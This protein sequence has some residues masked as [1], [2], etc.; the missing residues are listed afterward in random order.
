MAV[1]HKVLDSPAWLAMSHGARL[2]YISLRRRKPRQRNIVF[3]SY[4][5]AQA[6]LRSGPNKIAEWFRE[7]QYYGFIVLHELGCLGVDG[8]GKSPHWRLTE[9]GTT[10]KTS[11]NGLPEPP[12]R[13]YL[14]WN[15]VP[16][17]RPADTRAHRFEQFLKNKTPL[18]TPKRSATGVDNT[19]AT[20][21]VAPNT[22]SA[23]GVSYI[24]RGGTATGVANITSNHTG[25]REIAPSK[26][27][28]GRKNTV[29]PSAE[30]SDA[31]I[32]ALSKWG[33]A[34]TLKPWKARTISDELRAVLD[35]PKLHECDPGVVRGKVLE[36]RA[37]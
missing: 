23:T 15:G 24:E 35:L 33:R 14:Q 31:K 22:E 25:G 11:P 17:K 8:K 34:A 27:R 20:A 29:A 21:S 9:A 5:D 3:L 12:T 19:P 32:T 36:R 7:L 18:S 16:W 4:R 10:S 2:L 1:L 37:A 26:P 6:E 30:N 13:D 28:K